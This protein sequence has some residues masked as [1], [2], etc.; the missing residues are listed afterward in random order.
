MLPATEEEARNYL[1]RYDADHL[2]I[3]LYPILISCSYWNTPNPSKLRPFLS[4]VLVA[5]F[6][7]WIMIGICFC[8][9]HSYQLTASFFMIFLQEPLHTS[10]LEDSQ[11]WSLKRHPLVMNFWEILIR[12]KEWK[13]LMA[14]SSNSNNGRCIKGW[15]QGI[16]FFDGVLVEWSFLKVMFSTQ[17]IDDSGSLKFYA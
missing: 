16:S 10:R 4:Q 11:V 14:C 6:H 8:K 1:A 3:N 12:L 13:I 17:L 2:V 9:S 15:Q 7:I 5:D